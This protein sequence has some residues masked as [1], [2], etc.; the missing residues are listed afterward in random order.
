MSNRYLP[1][2]NRLIDFTPVVTLLSALLSANIQSF[3]EQKYA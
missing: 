2:L 3:Q 1:A